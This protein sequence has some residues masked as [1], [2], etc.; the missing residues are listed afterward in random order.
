MSTPRITGIT[1]QAIRAVPAPSD[2]VAAVCALLVGDPRNRSHV[3]A[4][5]SVVLADASSDPDQ[6]TTAN[7]RRLLLP[8]WVYPPVVGATVQRLVALGVLR[9]TGRWELCDDT[10]SGNRGKPQ[11]VYVLDP[12]YAVDLS[13]VDNLT[14]EPITPGST[15]QGATS[16]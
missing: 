14:R 13:T 16:A 15:D 6:V 3:H 8:S 5:V 9:P 2:P 10:V 11:P 12:V 1:E 4:V 7:R